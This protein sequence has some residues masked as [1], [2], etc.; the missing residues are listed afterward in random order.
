LR[1]NTKGSLRNRRRGINKQKDKKDLNKC[2]PKRK[3][4]DYHHVKAKKVINILIRKIMEIL[5]EVLNNKTNKKNIKTLRV[6]SL[7]TVLRIINKKLLMK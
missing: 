3:P 4:Y 2:L 5:I 7:S 1:R 6:N